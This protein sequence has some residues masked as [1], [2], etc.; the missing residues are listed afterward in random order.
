[1]SIYLGYIPTFFISL[2]LSSSMCFQIDECLRDEQ[3]FWRIEASGVGG[4]DTFGSFASRLYF[5][6][7]SLHF[8]LLSSRLT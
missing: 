3:R 5:P 6:S 8:C 1:M 4:C 2:T 7:C